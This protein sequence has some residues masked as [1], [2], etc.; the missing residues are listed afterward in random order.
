MLSMWNINNVLKEI[1]LIIIEKQVI[2]TSKL[3]THF[4]TILTHSLS[5][6]I[7]SIEVNR[8]RIIGNFIGPARYKVGLLGIDMDSTSSTSSSNQ[9]ISMEVS[10]DFSGNDVIALPMQPGLTYV[11]GASIS[12]IRADEEVH[13]LKFIY[14]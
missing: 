13:G 8:S 12:V 3:T 2:K 11:E 1:S 9:A 14:K 4:L 5:L 7:M 6:G 10:I